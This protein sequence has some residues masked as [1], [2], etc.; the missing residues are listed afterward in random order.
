MLKG[1]LNLF[2]QSNCPLCQ[3]STYDELC[4]YCARQLQSCHHKDP[5]CLWQDPIPIFG[6][7][8]YG[9]T[10]KR[11]IAVMKYENQPQMARPL[12]QLL[13]E[14]WLLNSPNRDKR[15]VVVPIP[16]HASKQK[17]RGYNQAALIAQSFCQTT[18]QKLKLNGLER[19]RETKAQFG[20]SASER[21]N[22]LVEAFAVGPELRDRRLDAPVLLV[23]DIYTT[24][25]TAFAAVQTLRQ[26]GI[27]VLGLA[28]VATAVKDNH[29]KKS[30]ASHP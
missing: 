28:A 29:T 1:L 15:L 23:D 27:A 17:Q 9:G 18:G 11:A 30:W 16:L 10:L 12:G 2:L 5:S 6:W 20:L 26:R 22:N 7:G 19:V 3:R 4:Q 8:V 21:E 25:A 13:G 14:A 24:G